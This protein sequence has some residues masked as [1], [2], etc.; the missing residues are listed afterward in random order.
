MIAVRRAGAVHQLDTIVL[1]REQS[2]R[3]LL[4]MVVVLKAKRTNEMKFK[5][6]AGEN[7]SGSYK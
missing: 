2:V 6:E 7:A 1:V 3:L 4:C 5:K